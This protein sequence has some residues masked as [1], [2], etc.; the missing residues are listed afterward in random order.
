[1]RSQPRPVSSS[2]V[3]SHLRRLQGD[4]K[5]RLGS[6]HQILRAITAVRDLGTEQGFAGFQ[7][8]SFE[9]L[10]RN[11]KS[12]SGERHPSEGKYTRV[13]ANIAV[14]SAMIAKARKI[15][16]LSARAN[17]IKHHGKEAESRMSSQAIMALFAA[18]DE[19]EG[20]IN[21]G[22]LIGH[23]LTTGLADNAKDLKT[24]FETVFSCSNVYSFHLNEALFASLFHTKKVVDNI[25]SV[26]THVDE[27]QAIRLSPADPQPQWRMPTFTRSMQIL[28]A[29]W[30]DLNTQKSEYVHI[31]KLA[32][33][34]VSRGIVGN[35][36]EGQ[37]L[38]RAV[39]NPV[40]EVYVSQAHYYRLFYPALLKAAMVNM[41]LGLACDYSNQGNS[42][43]MRLRMADLE[44]KVMLSG[45]KS[46][47][48]ISKEKTA[49]AVYSDF[50]KAGRPFKQGGRALD[51]ENASIPSIAKD[52]TFELGGS[53]SPTRFEWDTPTRS[54]TA[55]S[56]LRESHSVFSQSTD[57]PDPPPSR[58][59]QQKYFKS[60]GVPTF[61]REERLQ[62]ENR[63]HQHFENM[64]EFAS[65]LDQVLARCRVL[66]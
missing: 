8:E 28:Q 16:V 9:R 19:S 37:R 14:Q 27:G 41:A 61:T 38:V 36:H 29:W 22:T 32:D 46:H 57:T 24:A 15:Q 65:E 55:I 3:G 25:I 47:K 66:G 11:I 13:G 1:M 35:R 6:K 2:P 51:L 10:S 42:S 56:R 17:W 20:T 50:V 60:A 62:R 53:P 52:T 4:F 39:G 40:E 45:L 54:P 31:R 26:L 5:F 43:S 30:S 23:I 21:C 18:L 12:S 64:V 7:A 63:L 59:Q 34:M 48:S 49:F 33:F 58:L 44:R